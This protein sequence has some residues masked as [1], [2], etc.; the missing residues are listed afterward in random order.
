MEP[1]TATL[2]VL[3]AVVPL[4]DRAL[5]GRLVLRRERQRELC[6]QAHTLADGSRLVD[7][8]TGL[9]IEVGAPHPR[10]RR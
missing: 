1:V 7:L 2:A 10:G 9:L 5:R 6:R 4:A 8:D 3:G